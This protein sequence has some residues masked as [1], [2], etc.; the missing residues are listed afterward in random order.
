MI[1]FRKKREL[2]GTLILSH[3]QLEIK[4]G[5]QAFCLTGQD[6]QEL[7]FDLKAPMEQQAPLS[8]G[9][10]VRIP[11]PKGTYHCE[12]DMCDDVTFKAL[13]NYINH[14]E[15]VHK[16]QINLNESGNS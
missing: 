15:T 11:S 3:E 12:F 9:N 2:G 16:V 6:L 1:L 4:K 13:K 10:W 14:F 7:Q 8:G 5:K